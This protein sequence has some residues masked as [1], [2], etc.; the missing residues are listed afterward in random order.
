[1][2]GHFRIIDQPLIHTAPI[3]SKVAGIFFALIEGR[4]VGPHQIFFE[5]ISYSHGVVG[6]MSLKRSEAV[7]IGGFQ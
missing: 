7:V 1:M 4:L 6:R 5:T 3:E 2:L